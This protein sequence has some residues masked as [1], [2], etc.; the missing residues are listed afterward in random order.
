MAT[1][2]SLRIAEALVAALFET[3]RRVVAVYL[4]GS[5]ARNPAAAPR[6]LD[7]AF[8]MATEFDPLVDFDFSLRARTRF[9]EACGVPVD[10]VVL[11]TADPVLQYQVRRDGR[12]LLDRDR[13]ARLAWEVHSRK[14]WFDRQPAH[15]LF[16]RKVEERLLGAEA[17]HG[18]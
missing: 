4:F 7:L 3:D 2:H 17:D 6:D 14:L 13:A 10:V 18:R 1:G 8:L 9:E 5:A 11:N 15:A 16:M 12:V